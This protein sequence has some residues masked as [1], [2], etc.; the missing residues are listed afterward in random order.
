VTCGSIGMPTASVRLR[1]P[2]GEIRTHAAI[3]TGPVHAAYTAIDEV[4]GV[5]VSLLEFAVNAVTEGID[6]LGEVTVRV[7]YTCENNGDD[8]GD[9]L[10]PQSGESSQR[11]YG[12]HGADSDIIVASVRAYLAAINKVLVANGLYDGVP[13]QSAETVLAK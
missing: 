1:G 7:R 4:V 12:G 11:T 8:C 10:N 3:G 5:S 9:V 13:E 2:D 6:A